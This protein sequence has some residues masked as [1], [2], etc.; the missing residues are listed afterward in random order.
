M[1]KTLT[2]RQVAALLH[3]SRM[4]VE[5]WISDNTFPARVFADPGRPREWT[6]G[7]VLR[8]AV[9][10]RLVDTVGVDTKT[11]GILTQ[12]SVHGFHDD[13]A[14][15][16]AYSAPPKLALPWL[17][18]SVRKREIASF[19]AEGCE[20][21]FILKS[22]DDEATLAHNSRRNTGPASSAIIIDLDEIERD[23]KAAWPEA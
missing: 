18:R 11:A 21:P 12:T 8:L 10:V 7:E 6:F 23:L 15:F 14:F 4:R 22:G 5:K 2:L 3:I 17:A 1:P 13:G 16:V 9:F 20:Y 19:L